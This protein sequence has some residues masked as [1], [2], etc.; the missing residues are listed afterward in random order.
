MVL[1]ASSKLCDRVRAI[2]SDPQFDDPGC[3]LGRDE[4]I[5]GLV[6]EHGWDAVLE[7]M[8]SLLLDGA[9]QRHWAVAATVIWRGIDLPMPVV[10]VIA[11]LHLRL[12]ADVPPDQALDENLVWSIVSNLKGVSYLSDYDPASDP[13]VQEELARLRGMDEPPEPDDEEL[14]KAPLPPGAIDPPAD[15]HDALL[16]HI[17]ALRDDIARYS[18]QIAEIEAGRGQPRANATVLRSALK[19]RTEHLALMEA[20]LAEDS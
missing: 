20:R 7:E 17:R 15:P 3:D 9:G 11:L 12:L 5:W 13:E 8:L 10:P 14:A 16:A 2:L 1:E 4:L 6:V 18:R 19:H